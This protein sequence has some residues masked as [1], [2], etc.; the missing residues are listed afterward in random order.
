MTIRDHLRRKKARYLIIGALCLVATF[1]LIATHGITRQADYSHAGMA[2]LLGYLACVLLSQGIACPR[3]RGTV[4][5]YTSWF[6]LRLGRKHQRTNFCAHC[7]V[8]F[9]EPV[10]P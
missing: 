8:N 10:A 9:D 4:G 3:C 2:L 1:S 7:G 5:G 6:N